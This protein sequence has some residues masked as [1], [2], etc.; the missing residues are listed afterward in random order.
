VLSRVK[1]RRSLARNTV[2]SIS[3]ACPAY[4]TTTVHLTLP[5]GSTVELTTDADGKG[6]LELDATEPSSGVVSEGTDSESSHTV[7]YY[8][9]R[10]TCA[11]WRQEL[12]GSMITVAR[13]QRAA[14]ASQLPQCGVLTTSEDSP[15]HER[16]WEL[17]KKAALDAFAGNCQPV[18]KAA[19]TIRTLDLAHYDT[20][21]ARQPD[22]VECM[23]SEATRRKE[24]LARY[25]AALAAHEQCRVNRSRLQIAAQASRSLRERAQ[26]LEQLPVCGPAPVAPI[27]P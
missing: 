11:A 6:Q 26:R 4:E 15:K 23:Q 20:I 8:K 21:F 22:L 25:Q 27:E 19:A 9:D 16:A 2:A 17:T 3:N 7:R 13:E 14:I 5:S 24:E 12:F 10:A 18:A 1:P